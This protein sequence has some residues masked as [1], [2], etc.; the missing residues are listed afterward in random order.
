MNR[1]FY[2]PDGEGADGHYMEIGQYP[3]DERF[4]GEWFI[5]F[6]D[7][8]GNLYNVADGYENAP[9]AMWYAHKFRPKWHDPWAEEPGVC[10]ACGSH[11]C[12]APHMTA[13]GKTVTMWVE[14]S[15]CGS[16]HMEY[17][18]LTTSKMGWDE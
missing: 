17:Y 15:E 12:E 9:E 4:M 6:Y 2:A 10:P 1:R 18:E 7:A 11:D 3:N 16:T 13:N 14:C 8:D 5:R